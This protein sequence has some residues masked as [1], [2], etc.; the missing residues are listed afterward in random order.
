MRHARGK[1][2]RLPSLEERGITAAR[3][4]LTDA[5]LLE[6]I[7]SIHVQFKDAYG[8]PRMVD[9]LRDH[10]FPVSKTRWGG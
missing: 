9:E 2:E 1:R 7:R 10:E 5:Q 4:H 3:K 8:S 6:L